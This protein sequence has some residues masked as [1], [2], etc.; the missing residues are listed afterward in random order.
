MLGPQDERSLMINARTTYTKSPGKSI[1]DSTFIR[2]ARTV[3]NRTYV[4]KD[5]DR[6]FLHYLN[7]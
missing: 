2:E 4:H 5:A 3:N 6:K 1:G 7:S